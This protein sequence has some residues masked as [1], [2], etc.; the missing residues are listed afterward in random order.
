MQDMQFD[1]ILFPTLN[2][3]LFCLRVCIIIELIEQI[4]TFFSLGSID[5]LRAISN[6]G[7]DRD[8]S[9]LRRSNQRRRLGPEPSES[10]SRTP[11]RKRKAI[12]FPQRKL[13]FE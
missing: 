12:L 6:S 11:K 5:C 2:V 9:E 7:R 13:E 4:F 1:N 3:E 10:R 8:W